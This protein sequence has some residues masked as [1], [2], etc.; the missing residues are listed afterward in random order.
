MV[1]LVGKVFKGDTVV[2]DSSVQAYAYDPANNIK[3][4][5]DVVKTDK[6]GRYQISF[7]SISNFTHSFSEETKII[8]ASWEDDNKRESTHKVFG[9]AICEYTGGSLCIQDIKIYK[10]D[11]ADYNL[12]N[13]SITIVQKE[14]KKYTPIF[15][16][17]TQASLFYGERI[18]PQ[19][20]VAK[21]SVKSGKDFIKP[22]KLIFED[23]G[24]KSLDVRGVSV[25]GNVFIGTVNISVTKAEEKEAIKLKDIPTST[26]L[27]FFVVRDR[28]IKDNV[29]NANIYTSN[30]FV[31]SKIQI[32]VDDVMVKEIDD[33]SSPIVSIT[34][35]SKTSDTRHVKM[36]VDGNFD[37]SLKTTEYI[38]EEDV[39]NYVTITGDMSTSLN[40]DTGKQ[41]AALHINNSADV[42]SIMWQIVYSSTVIEK[43]VKVTDADE[44]A[45]INI[46][47]QKY[48][49]P[50]VMSLEFET[51]QPGNYEIIAYAINNAGVYFKISDSLF[52]PGKSDSSEQKIKV[53]DSVTIGCLSNHGEVP[54]LDVYRLSRDGYEKLKSIPM[55]KAFDKTYFHDY[56]IEKDQSFYIFKT[57]S[58]V[59]VKK[60]GNPGGCAIAYSKDKTTGRKI[61]YQL[62]DFKGNVIDH[63]IL[64]DSGFGVYYKV[65]SAKAHG[66]LLIGKTYKV[67]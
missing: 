15:E 39:K 25:S 29:L 1:T 13:D 37:G 53:G 40:A 10:A 27:A 63:G 62:Q 23:V 55:D 19:N 57:E 16:S 7:G 34:L 67:V 8:L 22:Y 58:S 3:E 14:E 17:P 35:T 38:Y 31:P 64:N 11:Y 50:S 60:V 59:V 43:V 49:D 44:K 26:G 6:N 52:V 9:S 4:W 56:T 5:S 41:T 45:L 47:Y 18:F 2:S 20:S 32:V 28:G 54:I 65:F 24:E 66:M 46:L 33:F 12:M 48:V 61:K 21:V 36:I 42:S 51:L 30:K